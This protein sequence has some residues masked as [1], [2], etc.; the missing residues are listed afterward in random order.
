[1][2]LSRGRRAALLVAGVVF[3]VGASSGVSWAL[4]SVTA[5]TTA[6]VAAGS[7]GITANNSAAT[8]LLALNTGALGPGTA[9]TS[10]VT[11]T[12]TGTVPLAY[13][14]TLATALA[15]AGA[16]IGANVDYVVWSTSSVANCTNLASIASPN[17]SGNFG[18][19]KATVN[20]GRALAAGASEILCVRTTM[21]TTAPQAAQGQSVT[22][23]FT[24][25]GTS[26]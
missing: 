3:L 19:A 7:V 11:V 25:T 21:K 4:W 24:F 15:P 16:V 14:T 20:S 26:A 13:S 2:S 1:M 10:S 12:N 18:T 9:L 23:T 6:T 5:S 17:W 22:A 8:T